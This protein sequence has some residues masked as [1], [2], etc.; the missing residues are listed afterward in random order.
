[1]SETALTLVH[2]KNALLTSSVN[3]MFVILSKDKRTIYLKDYG[4]QKHFLN[5]MTNRVS[6]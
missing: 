1:M 6:C 3:L 5:R 4:A 2:S